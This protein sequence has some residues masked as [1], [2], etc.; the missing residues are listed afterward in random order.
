MVHVTR[1]YRPELVLF[2]PDERLTP[3]LILDAGK[4]IRVNATESG[5][6]LVSRFA[7]GQSDRQI[8]CSTKMDEIVRAIV[9]LGGTYPDVVQAFAQAKSTR[10]LVCRFEVDAVPRKGRIYH[11][12][13]SPVVKQSEPAGFPVDSP[14]PDLY[15]IDAVGQDEPVG[16]D[17]RD[18][19]AEAQQEPE[20]RWPVA[21]AVGKIFHRFRD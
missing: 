1:T 13:T 15:P 14:D 17:P 3:P 7:P 5:K 21:G 11:Q 20:N 9:D 6:V 18:E 10:S 16:A 2:G 8:E 19:A 12:E 4:H